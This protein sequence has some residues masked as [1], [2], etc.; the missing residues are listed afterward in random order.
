MLQVPGLWDGGTGGSAAAAAAARWSKLTDHVLCSMP[1]EPAVLH[2]AG[3]PS[4]FVGH[5][6]LHELGLS[7]STNSFGGKGR[8][9]AGLLKQRQQQQQQQQSAVSP[10]QHQ[11]HQQQ[12]QVS[13]FGPGSAAAFWRSYDQARKLQQQAAAAEAAAAAAPNASSSSELLVEA[14]ARKVLQKLVPRPQQQEQ[15][16]LLLA[17]LP[18]TSEAEVASSMVC[19][20]AITTQLHARYPHLIATLHVPEPLVLAA[21]TAVVNFK[22]PVLVVAA[23]EQR[24]ADAL[25]AAAAA[26]VHPG[27]ASLAAVAAG[28][29]LVCVRDVS[30]LKSAWDTFRLKGGL[31][32]SSIP[33]LLLGRAAFPE[34]KV[35]Q[36]DKAV[37][38]VQLLLEAW[39]ATTAPAAGAH[40]KAGQEVIQQQKGLLQEA[41]LQLVPH[42]QQQQGRA[43]SSSTSSSWQLPADAAAQALV[44]LIEL[45]QQQ[46][47]EGQHTGSS[48]S[49]GQKAIR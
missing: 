30:F 37:N 35:W 24:A 9:L 33:N 14:K 38:H 23:N 27:P 48:S 26:V 42:E 44:D 22:V 45:R 40:F 8:L 15:Q 10:Q 39:C 16:R 2:A 32:Y 20:D 3:V 31:P 25:A 34:Y 4:T 6:L 49:S 17:L 13:L 11:Q 12:K 19:F 29:P 46:E 1:F 43:R 7:A 21:A 41:L 47:A 5:P 28:T 36:L 18:G